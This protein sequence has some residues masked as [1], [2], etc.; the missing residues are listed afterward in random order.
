MDDE[1]GE[2]TEKDDVT[3][4]RRRESEIQRWDEVD[5]EKQGTSSGDKVKH[6]ERCKLTSEC[7]RASAAR[8]L[9][10]D[11]VMQISSLSG[12]EHLSVSK[13]SLYNRRVELL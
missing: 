13:M 3:G 2:S 6:V 11:K 1:S 5:G 7:R 4:A 10:I 12:C 9:N 8:R